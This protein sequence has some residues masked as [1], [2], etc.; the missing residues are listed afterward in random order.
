MPFPRSIAL[1]SL[2]ALGAGACDPTPAAPVESEAEAAAA[3]D[4]AALLGAGRIARLPAAQRAAWTEYVAASARRKAAERAAVEAEAR[5]AGLAGIRPAP[6]TPS[7]FAVTSAMTESWLRSDAGRATTASILSYQTPSGGWGKHVD[8]ARGPRAPGQ[9]YNGDSDAWAYVGTLD[10]N[11][12]TGQLQYLARAFAATGD[13][14]VRAAFVRGI[15]YLAAAQYPNGCWP[16]TYPLD[17]GY[18]DAVTFNDDA[19]THVL[20]LLRD[21]A[22]GGV[23][24]F[25]PA[26]ARE[27]AAA[28]LARG[29]ECAAAA[30]VRVGGALAAWGQQHDPLTLAPT[31]GRSY[32]LP[33][34]ASGESA[35]L[36]RVLMSLPAPDARTRAAVHAAAD[37]FTRSQQLGVAY[38]AAAGT[39]TQRAGAGPIWARIVEVETGRAIFANRDGV[40]LYDFDRL[41]DRRTGYTWFGTWPASALSQYATWAR[42]NLRP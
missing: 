33:G 18:H 40:K 10:N 3:R 15:D 8:H 24:A 13:T 9:G 7:D 19:M 34:L 14:L 32:E 29:V 21:V 36:V 2:I 41:T 38:D 17:G 35:S 22:T 31:G 42:S 1:A 27:R 28:M 23:Y 30:Q 6:N 37:W 26:A 5:A 11:A 4:T 20:A 16:Q 25:A 12:T 39:L